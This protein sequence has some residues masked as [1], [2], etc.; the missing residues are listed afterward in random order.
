MKASA[1]K[2]TAIQRKEHNVENSVGYNAVADNTG[3]HSFILAVV[4]CQICKILRKFELIG[5]Q[6][7]PRSSILVPIKSEYATSY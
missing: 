1:K 3:L 4:A 2:S 6:D 5:V 7:H